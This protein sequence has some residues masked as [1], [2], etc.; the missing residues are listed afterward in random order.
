MLLDRAR[1]LRRRSSA[2]HRLPCQPNKEALME[3]A[4]S[5]CRIRH[6]EHSVLWQRK[7]ARLLVG[8]LGLIGCGLVAR[9]ASAQ[10]SKDNPTKPAA[11][12]GSPAAPEA[13]PAAP[14]PASSGPAPVAP[15][16]PEAAPAS[17]E[18]ALASPE[19]AA[20]PPEV[21]ASARVDDA[22][23]DSAGLDEV[24]VTVDR[25]R[26]DLQKYSGTASAF[27]ETK[28]SQVGIVGVSGLSSVVPGLQ[29]GVQEGNTEVYIRGVGNDNNTEHGDMGVAIHLDGIYLPRPR[30]VGA[31]FYDVERVEV[32]SGPQGTLRG[33]NAMGGSINI[34]TN[35]PRLGEFGANAQAVFGTFAERRY[36]GMVNIPLG[37][38]VA[39]RFA[40]LSSVHDPYWQ[41]GGPLYDLKAAESED[42]YALRGQIKWQPVPALNVIAGYDFVAERG[43]G[44][45]GANHNEPLNNRND[46]GTPNDITDD[47]PE[48]IPPDAIDNPRRVYQFGAQPSMDMKH[49]GARLEVNYDAG[50]FIVEALASYRDLVFKQVNGASA[51]VIYPGYDFEQRAADGI[52]FFGTAYWDTRSQS[53]VTE[54]RLSAP[55]TARLRWTAGGFFMYE[56]Q[57]VVLYT[58]AD[59][60]GGYGGAEFNMPDVYEHSVAGFAD[61]TFDVASDFR[62]LGGVRL[63]N[64]AKGRRNGLAMQ[65][66]GIVGN[67]SRFA[68]EGFRPAYRDRPTY[69][70][71][72]NSTA[73][74]RVNLFLDG[75]ASFG[76]RD[77]FPQEICNDPPAA[78]AGQP[79]QPRVAI[80]PTTGTLRCTEGVDDALVAGNGFNIS[81]VQ[82]N[83]EV[84][85]TFFDYRL[86]A[87]YDLAK[88]SLLYLTLSTAHKA[89]G[90]NDT[91]IRPDGVQTNEYYG[92]ESVTALEIGSKN[93]LFGRKL[94][95]NASAFLYLYRDQVFQQV[96]QIAPSNPD[97]GLAPQATSL[98]QN[99]AD[100]NLYGLDLDVTYA[101]PLGLEVAVHALLLDARYS[102]R[103]LVND[104]RIA[105]GLSSYEVDINGHWLPRASPYAFN[106]SLSQLIF[107]SAGSFNWL[108][109]GQTVGQHYM[110]VFN[111]H[112]NYLPEANGN[113]PAPGTVAAYDDLLIDAARLTDIVPTYTRF[114]LGGGWTH[115]DGR[116][117]LDAYVNNVFN[118]AYATSIISSPNLNLRFFNPPRTAGVRF[119]VSW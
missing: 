72:P 87:E 80:D 76:A 74:D 1:E 71:P 29:I 38:K 117:S 23:A 47:Y 84:G 92:P 69:E 9:V 116:I 17:P 91:V 65:R 64:E 3:V 42:S 45:L 77:T 97:A 4:N 49:Q 53:T 37:D 24:V 119:R 83:S 35:K 48:T 10:A 89:A 28:L 40:G 115:P 118:I 22:N 46:N 14:A 75:I 67:N 107:T 96:V 93:E 105:F 7:Q 68:T 112:G 57:Q 6:T 109:Q 63:T 99:A 8:M 60:V 108:A 36:Q 32:N 31:M 51:G 98:R 110:T 26:K 41:N 82:Q 2:E 78:V 50:P 25:R 19:V 90:Y 95:L 81:A 27:T 103:T 111:G 73:E 101:L 58:T 106:Y 15:A 100:P 86:G 30:G 113:P 34:V 88:T 52:D 85:N 94:R 102:E 66:G 20:A 55:D 12:E 79:Q 56:T 54:L 39:V 61:A 62:V 16:S 11:S 13:Q 21:A 114:D 18:V 59:P 43:N 70:L 104:G 5:R 33:R 44:S